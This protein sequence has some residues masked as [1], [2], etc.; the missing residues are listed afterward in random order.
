MSKK[1]PAKKVVENKEYACPEC[2]KKSVVE[3]LCQR[4]AASK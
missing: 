2:G 1:K 3:G 4:H